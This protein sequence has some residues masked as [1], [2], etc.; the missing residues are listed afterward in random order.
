MRYRK[1]LRQFLPI[2]ISI[3]ER[4][5][6]FDQTYHV[7]NCRYPYKKEAPEINVPARYFKYQK[8]AKKHENRGE[9]LETHEQ[10]YQVYSLRT[11][12]T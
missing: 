3:S 8:S 5:T 4:I 1:P 7:E 10:D 6:E 9:R 12:Y 11:R 2:P